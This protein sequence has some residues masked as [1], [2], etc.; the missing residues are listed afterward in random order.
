MS[1]IIITQPLVK[2]YFS[3]ETYKRGLRKFLKKSRGPHAVTAS[4]IRGLEELSAPYTLNPAKEKILPTDTVWINESL[5]A[6][7]WV[8]ASP[9]KNNP[10]LV[11]PNLVITPLDHHEIICDPA[12]DVILQ[13]SDWTKDFML[14]L[15]PILENK[16]V[17]WPAG[18]HIPERI[19]V[20]KTIDVLI[21]SKNKGEDNILE[22]VVSLCRERHLSFEIIVYGTFKQSEYFEKLDRAKM[23]VYISNSESQGLALQEAWAHN[24]PTLVFNR[25]YYNYKNHYFDNVK[26]SA[27]YLSEQTG[28]FFNTVTLESTFSHFLQNLYVFTPREWVSHNLSDRICA[29]KFLDIISNMEHTRG[30]VSP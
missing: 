16:V 18:V 23:L 30:K 3:V 1:L 4:V 7:R 28:I 14:S 12:I 6:L 10:L 22:R 9:H 8:L 11:G 19:L 21:Y 29:Q 24:I 17:I 25:G 27:P 20:K 5:E 15:K 26:I 13:P 2:S